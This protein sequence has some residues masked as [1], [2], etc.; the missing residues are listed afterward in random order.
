MTRYL[1]YSI[2]FCQLGT[3]QVGRSLYPTT[4]KFTPLSPITEKWGYLL[5]I[6]TEN[7]PLVTQKIAG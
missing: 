3:A 4:G 6:S 1:S 5:C 2:L 7:L